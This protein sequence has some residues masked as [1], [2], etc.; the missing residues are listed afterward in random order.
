MSLFQVAFFALT[1]VDFNNIIEHRKMN[2]CHVDV[3]DVLLS[4]FALV[5]VI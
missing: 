3:C 1:F 5:K 4:C 2:I